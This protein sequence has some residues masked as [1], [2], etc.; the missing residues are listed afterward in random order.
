MA[1]RSR[2][3]VDLIAAKG[4]KHLTFSEYDERK[5]KEVV[6]PNDNIKAPTFLSKKEAEKFDEIA[7]VLKDIGI[8]TNLDC[9]VLGMYIQSYTQYEKITKQINK[10]KFRTDK[11]VDV[12]ADEQLTEQI[13][14]FGYL[15]KLQIRYLKACTECAKE[16]GLTISSRCKLVLPQPKDDGKPQNKFLAKSS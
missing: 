1:G 9:D 12:D 13:S 7:N 10:I 11:K 5:S 15:S 14:N 3:P 8:M 2:Q 6:A 16:L 4:R